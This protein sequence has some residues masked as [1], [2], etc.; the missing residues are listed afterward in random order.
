M[1]AEIKQKMSELP[2]KFIALP[3]VYLNQSLYFD[4]NIDTET[5]AISYNQIDSKIYFYYR[6]KK[7]VSQF[8]KHLEDLGFIANKHLLICDVTDK[9]IDSIVAIF[10]ETLQRTEHILGKENLYSNIFDVR[11]TAGLQKYIKNINIYRCVDKN[12]IKRLTLL[13]NHRLESEMA[14]A[15]Y[16]KEI[17]DIGLLELVYASF[18][19]IDK[20]S[21]F[22]DHFKSVEPSITRIQNFM[23][24]PLIK[25]LQVKGL[26]NSD[27]ELEDVVYYKNKLFEYLSS[28]DAEN[29][30]HYNNMI[31][32]FI[33]IS[34]LRCSHKSLNTQEAIKVFEYFYSAKNMNPIRREVGLLMIIEYCARNNVSDFFKLPQKWYNYTTHILKFIMHNSILDT[35]SKTDLWHLYQQQVHKSNSF[36]ISIKRKVAVCISGVYR[37]HPESLKSIK[38]KIVDQLEA[39][40]FIHTWDQ[41]NLWSGFGGSAT[42]RRIL[43]SDAEKL[44]PKDYYW[45]SKL[46]KIFP[47]A[48]PIL[49][50]VINQNTDKKIFDVVTP[51]KIQ[52]ESESSFINSLGDVSSYTRLRGISN[53]IKMFHGIKQSF[54]MALSETRYDYIIRC[55]PDIV[56]TEVISNNLICSLQN[57][58]IYTSSIDVGLGDSLFVISSAMA[59]DFSR[60]VSLMY[61]KH[62]LS[63]FDEFPDYDSHNLLAAWMNSNNY[64]YSQEIIKGRILNNA[65]TII[66]SLKESLLLDYAQLSDENKNKF[67]DF[68]E[69]LIKRNG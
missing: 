54:D 26:A 29:A 5:L 16:L 52:I 39:D 43:G 69:Y 57:N 46:E 35:E 22:L 55:R 66:P 62:E 7:Q 32:S 60:F 25:E 47:T 2:T 53:Q 45:L 14:Y 65:K 34:L 56:I 4:Y 31:L 59:Y 12:L 6:S 50:S 10:S 48:Y 15:K 9:S 42:S 20:N 18:E 17:C 19:I 51:S 36:K 23:H 61:E 21:K 37:N 40:V 41:M 28:I 49:K 30:T 68:V 1:L 11:Q 38:E 13:F 24:D 58:T 8:V 63:P 27:S 64:S 33:L 44:L 3:K 67:K